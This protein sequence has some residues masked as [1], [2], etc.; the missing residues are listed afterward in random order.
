ME[1]VMEKKS[2]NS[3]LFIDFV[4]FDFAKEDSANVKAEEIFY[5]IPKLIEYFPEDKF[6]REIS[7][8]KKINFIKD[9]NNI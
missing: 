3:Y 8:I 9:R 2:N 4:N 6:I 1:L 5:F 7:N